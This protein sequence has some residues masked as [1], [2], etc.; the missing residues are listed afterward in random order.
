MTSTVSNIIAT[1]CTMAQNIKLAPIRNAA[2]FDGTKIGRKSGNALEFV[3]Y[4]D[5]QQGDDIRRLDWNIL[6]RTDKLLVKQY[7]QEIDPRCDIVIDQSASIQAGEGKPDA[8]LAI[9]A[10]LAI[11]ADNAAFSTTIWHAH[12]NWTKDPF[13][14]TPENWTN[15][16]FNAT[17]SPGQNAKFHL[18][19]I[20]KR[21]IR[22]IISDFLWPQNPIELLQ[23]FANGAIK[24]VAIQLLNPD[25]INPPPGGIATLIDPENNERRLLN[26]D[27]KTIGSYK[28]AIKNHLE[29]WNNAAIM[30]GTQFIQVN[31]EAFSKAPNLEPFL[32][33][34]I[35]QYL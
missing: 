10:I 34:A 5:Y 18:E 19:K 8:A 32:K 7:A 26:L 12:D 17:L 28:Q 11:A 15:L 33:A 13:P 31:A 22:F 14:T 2:G 3:E 4:R 23:A 9:A 30:T 24:T 1:A 27:E 16:D 25:E 29:L 35:I 21:G 20:Q 6:A